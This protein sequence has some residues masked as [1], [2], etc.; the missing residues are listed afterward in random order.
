ML[1]VLTL[2]YPK[3][4]KG[5]PIITTGNQELLRFFKKT[6]LAEWRRRTDGAGDEIEAAISRAELDR[7]SRVLDLLIPDGENLNA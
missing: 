1:A 2:H 3:G 4:Q 5:I 6:I 7:L